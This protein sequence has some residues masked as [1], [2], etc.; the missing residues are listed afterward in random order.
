MSIKIFAYNNASEG[1][2]RLA[3]ALGTN[4][5]KHEG[6]RWQPRTRDHILNWG[7]G[8]RLPPRFRDAQIINHPD[9]V[10]AA[11]NKLSAFNRMAASGVSVPPYTTDREVA[12]GWGLEGSRIV[13]RAVLRGSGGEGASIWSTA[14]GELPRAPLYTKY[15]PKGRATGHPEQGEYR[16][17]VFDGQVI[18]LQQKVRRSGSGG[19]NLIRSHDNGVIFIRGGI[20]PAPAVSEQALA[21]VRAL[22]LTFGGVDVLYNHR[23]GRAFV[24]EVN[25]APGLE[26]ST[27]GHYARAIE[28]YISS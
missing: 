7:W 21:A 10:S 1:A 14:S 22:G 24:L 17:H 26:G 12:R 23:Q 2:R 5:L 6:S 25:T 16:V 3:E 28:R 4:L 13:V 27:T 9:L 15:I 11:T 8:G 20:T 18:D 19:D